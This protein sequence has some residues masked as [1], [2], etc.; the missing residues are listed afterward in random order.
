MILPP[1]LGPPA[2]EVLARWPGACRQAS[3]SESDLGV[4]AGSGPSQILT[5][6]SKT[7]G[8]PK[9]DPAEAD[10]VP[11]GEEAG[12]TAQWVGPGRRR[13]VASELWRV[14]GGD[15][16]PTLTEARRAFGRSPAPGD[17]PRDG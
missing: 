2:S 5:Q 4:D 9:A 7:L 17:R 15:V 10:R 14:L 3:S 8:P 6:I 12:E 16:R 13:T 1:R 11:T